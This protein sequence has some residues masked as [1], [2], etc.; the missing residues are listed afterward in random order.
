[1]NFT[2]PAFVLLFPLVLALH[3][4]LPPEAGKWLLLSASLLFYAMGDLHAFPLL[5]I[6]ILITW[7]GALRISTAASQKVKTCLAVVSIC[8]VTGTLIYFKLPTAVF[9]PAGISFYTFQALSYVAGV[10]GG[11]VPAERDPFSY[12]L[13][14]SFFPQLVAGP[15]EPP[16]VLL[17]QLKACRKITSEDMAAGVALLLRGYIKNNMWTT[18]FPCP[19]PRDPPSRPGLSCSVCRSTRIFQDTAISPAAVHAC[20]GSVCPAI[21]TGHILPVASGISGGAGTLP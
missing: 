19:L 5:L 4:L 15:I 16:D 11:T 13:Y 18:F 20:W 14:I 21:L 9:L 8:A 12:A 7:Y 10:Y 17:P 6:L 3:R 2:S 1:M